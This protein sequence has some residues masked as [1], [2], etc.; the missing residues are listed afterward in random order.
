MVAMVF[1]ACTKTVVTQSDKMNKAGFSGDQEL[2]V[3]YQGDYGDGEFIE[4]AVAK[5]LPAT[6][7]AISAREILTDTSKSKK[8]HLQKLVEMGKTS[9]MVVKVLDYAKDTV[10]VQV[11]GRGERSLLED[12]SMGFYGNQY[13]GV[14]A[15]ARYQEESTREEFD[16]SRPQAIQVKRTLRLQ[17]DI[18]DIKSKERIYNCRTTIENPPSIKTIGKS[19]GKAVGKDLKT[20]GLL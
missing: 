8:E 18:Y 1:S 3:V 12:Q 5:G 10:Q 6:L 16:K 14:D 17:G 9:L 4:S 19:F 13:Y 7:N 2:V 11:T 15:S 20:T